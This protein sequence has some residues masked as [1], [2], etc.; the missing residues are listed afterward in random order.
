MSGTPSIPGSTIELV[1]LGTLPDLPD[2]RMLASA[3]AYHEYLH[4]APL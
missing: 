4:T 3:T 1:N 2:E